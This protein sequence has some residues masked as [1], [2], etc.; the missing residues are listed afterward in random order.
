[1]DFEIL[2]VLAALPALLLLTACAVF[3]ILYVRCRRECR[4]VRSLLLKET[5]CA[6]R[7]TDFF[8]NMTHEMKTPLSVILGALQLIEL[9]RNGQPD[10]ENHL[11]GNLKIIK[12]NCYRLLRLTNNLLDLTKMEAGYLKL[13]AVNCDLI[14]LLEEIV[15]SVT[16]YAVQKQLT[17]Y[18]D[19]PIEP[20]ITAV[21]I[22]K[23]ERIMLNLLSNAIK[24]TRP[25][26]SIHV[27]A[28]MA[29]NRISI[30]V[31][32]SGEGI[33][34]DKQDE[35]F[36]RFKQA[37]SCTSAESEGSGIGLSLVKSFVEIHQ[38]SIRIISEQG[39]GC[40]FIIDLPVRHVG[41]NSEV[42]AATDFNIRLAEATKIEFSPF[43]YIAS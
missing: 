7:K 22:E 40:E 32:D 15:Q 28:H 2:Y 16:P 11:T 39:R 23:T 12:Y 27:S 18:F 13:N 25:G 9:K 42:P 41:E 4:R 37:G 38:G 1:M 31:K 30:S 8:T 19:K 14:L 26:G 24:F 29:D 43:H 20:I 34:S 6:V 33:P 36:S 21:D 5:E 17:L 3:F 35:V 10:E